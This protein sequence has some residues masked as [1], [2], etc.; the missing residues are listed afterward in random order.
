MKQ[1][2]VI[3]RQSMD[4]DVPRITEIY[5]RSVTEDTAS[6]E[7]EPPDVP[8]MMRRRSALLDASFPYLVAELDGRVEGYAYAGA[9]RP[10]PAYSF[11]VESTVYVDPDIQRSGVGRALMKRLIEECTAR[12]YRQMIA[13]IGGSQHVASIEFHKTLGFQDAGIFNSVGYK[14]GN[15]LD[16]VQL[17]LALG[18][19]DTSPPDTVPGS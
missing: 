13:I 19:G 1:P 11:T 9:I 12:G 14:H 2:E 18:P 5:G 10:R 3:I 6:F 16:T 17:Q 15:W 7:F 4:A 8:E